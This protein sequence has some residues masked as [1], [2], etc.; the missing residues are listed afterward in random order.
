MY[1][2]K[3]AAILAY[4]H[5]QENLLQYGY[6]PIVGTL[7]LWEHETRPTKFCVCVDDFGIKYSS[8]AD[9]EHLLS[10]LAKHYKLTT[11]RTGKNYCGLNFDWH[12]DDGYVDVSMPTYTPDSLK[13]LKHVLKTHPQYSP[14]EPVTIRYGQ[15][16]AR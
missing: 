2:L 4:R 1:G 13:R 5:L 9:A 12:Y 10:S 11:D 8:K 7:G 3:Q 6:K 16:G 15:K 14:H